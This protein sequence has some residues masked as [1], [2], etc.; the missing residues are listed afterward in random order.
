MPISSTL[1]RYDSEITEPLPS[2]QN[3]NLKRFFY[4]FLQELS[5]EMVEVF[6]M[7]SRDVKEEKWVMYNFYKVVFFTKHL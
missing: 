1:L 6:C 2:L 5:G 4:S 7:E 3:G